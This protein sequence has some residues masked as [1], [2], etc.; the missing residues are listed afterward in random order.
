MWATILFVVAT[1]QDADAQNPEN[2]NLATEMEGMLANMLHDMQHDFETTHKGTD[3]AFTAQLTGAEQNI[4]QLRKEMTDTLTRVQDAQ[5]TDWKKMQTEL[6]NANSLE[7]THYKEITT[8][9]NEIKSMAN[10][11]DSLLENAQKN[12]EDELTRLQKQSSNFPL[13]LAKQVNRVHA[14][15]QRI[16]EQIESS[17]HTLI[18]SVKDD[19]IC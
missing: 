10:D 7:Q 8:R 17:M 19:S 15:A 11:M 18:D 6:R 5:S 9:M 12:V 13:V 4:E 2:L 14:E 3:M 1:G 16:T